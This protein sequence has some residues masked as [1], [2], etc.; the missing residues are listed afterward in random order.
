[1]KIGA[2]R[3]ESDNR[4]QL[5]KG[6]V[7]RWCWGRAVGN[8]YPHAH[9]S[10]VPHTRSHADPGSDAD[11]SASADCYVGTRPHRYFGAQAYANLSSPGRSYP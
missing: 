4:P 10:P 8:Q 2:L 9:R 1:M 7:R 5:W 11:I 6:K 3:F